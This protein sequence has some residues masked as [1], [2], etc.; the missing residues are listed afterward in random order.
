MAPGQ[1]SSVSLTIFP[2]LLFSAAIVVNGSGSSLGH[3]PPEALVMNHSPFGLGASP[4]PGKPFPSPGGAVQKSE[5]VNGHRGSSQPKG[6]RRWRVNAK[7]PAELS[8]HCRRWE[9]Q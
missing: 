5:E 3:I 2:G 9:S 8:S 4:V 6:D 1:T 7:T